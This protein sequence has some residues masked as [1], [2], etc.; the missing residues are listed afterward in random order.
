[1]RCRELT[2]AAVAGLRMLC[3]YLSVKLAI[4]CIIVRVQ[5]NS[6]CDISLECYGHS[7]HVGCASLCC[8]KMTKRI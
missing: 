5:Q 7:V 1:V 3:Y 6:C 2:A 4:Y 8:D